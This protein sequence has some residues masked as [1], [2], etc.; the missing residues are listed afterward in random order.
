MPK[1]SPLSRS[2]DGTMAD[3][4]A[5]SFRRA[6]LQHAILLLLT[7]FTILT[8]PDAAIASTTEVVDLD[9]DRA[10][11][12]R[13]DGPAA[14]SVILIPGGS[15]MLDINASGTRF[16][17][18]KN[19]GVRTRAQYVAAGYVAILVHDPTGL[20]AAIA[21][22][23]TLA[24]PVFL[25]GTSNGTMVAASN[26]STLG[27]DGPDGVV[28]TSSI[29]VNAAG[30]GTVLDSLLEQIGVPVLIVANSRDAYPASPSSGAQRIAA[31]LRPAQVTAI[32]VS[33][34]AGRSG[35]CNAPAPYG[36]FGRETQTVSQIIAWIK[37]H[38]GP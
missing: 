14:G 2:I 12:I 10:V 38:D 21:R 19:F 15:T 22:A 3:A 35:P 11:F 1:K 37:A 26:A 24:R 4:I 13:P 8:V 17:N 29:T 5:N 25:V 31:R 36:Y 9:G 18:G 34:V 23:R 27:S 20:A 30:R 7:T 6:P 28:L 16:G 33:S 32:S